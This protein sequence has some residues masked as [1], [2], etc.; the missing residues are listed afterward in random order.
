M[1]TI[2]FYLLSGA[3]LLLLFITSLGSVGSNVYVRITAEHLILY[4]FF[5]AQ[6]T[7]IGTYLKKT[8]YTE[9]VV[10]TTTTIFFIWYADT[11]A[12]PADI[13]GGSA[14]TLILLLFV[15]FSCILHAA[16]AKQRN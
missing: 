10:L 5:S 15:G 9:L 6:C 1:R 13:L 3:A 4:G 7:K 12:V 8:V 11:H 2:F 14:L 16:L